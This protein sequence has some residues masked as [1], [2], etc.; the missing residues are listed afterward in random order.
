VVRRGC[1][2]PPMDDPVLDALAVTAER[3]QE[4]ASEEH[5]HEQAEP[6][7]VV[8]ARHGGRAEAFDYMAG[9]IREGLF[10]SLDS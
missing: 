1:H 5:A 2:T 4:R 6:D 9:E 8:A 10:R 3:L 7:E